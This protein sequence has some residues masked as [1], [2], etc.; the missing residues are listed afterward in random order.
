MSDADHWEHVHTL[1]HDDSIRRYVRIAGLLMLL[2]EDEIAHGLG[3]PT[4]RSDRHRDQ[5]D[6]R[7]PDRRH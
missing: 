6:A 2:F 4:V 1:L 7:Q 5:P 3:E